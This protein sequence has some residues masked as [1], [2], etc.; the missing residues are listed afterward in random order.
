[1]TTA[2]D[3]P[4]PTRILFDLDGTLVH[5]TPAVIESYRHAFSTVLGYSYPTTSAEITDALSVRFVELCRRK[6]GARRDELITAFRQRH[7]GPADNL[8]D[9][10][11]SYDGVPA[12]FGGLAARTI[13]IGLV[14]NK[15]RVAAEH[16]LRRCGL[17]DL[18]WR[19][20]ITADEATRGK[21]DPLPLVLAL[22]AINCPPATAAYIGDAPHDITAA[23]RAG[24]IA[25]G[26]AYGD[27]GTEPSRAAGA[28]VLIHTPPQLLDV[29]DNWTGLA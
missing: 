28:E 26:A 19:C 29:I 6:A 10:P 18:P 9:P 27:W 20:I 8:T 22:E 3:R 21:P 25:I 7:L 13:D 11:R 14:T 16:E 4:V 24:L 15:T 5:T 1:M 23:H 2:A 12:M 17:D